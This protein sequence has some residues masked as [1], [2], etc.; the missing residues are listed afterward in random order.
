MILFPYYEALEIDPSVRVYIAFH[1]P[2]GPIQMKHIHKVQP[3]EIQ[4]LK[5]LGK[6]AG[7]QR[8]FWICQ[9]RSCFM[10]QVQVQKDAYEINLLTCNAFINPHVEVSLPLLCTQVRLF[11][12]ITPTKP[13]RMVDRV[14]PAL[15]AH[16][17]VEFQ[18]FMQKKTCRIGHQ[19]FPVFQLFSLFNL[20]NDCG[21]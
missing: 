2:S 7:L 21:P 8:V 18:Q 4:S 6:R 11:L 16:V 9:G 5:S 3:K 12:S 17:Q 1:F 13:Q 19:I 10:Q 20:S 15:K 14:R